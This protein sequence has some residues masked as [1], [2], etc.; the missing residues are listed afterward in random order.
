MYEVWTDGSC[1]PKKLS[2]KRRSSKG[3]STIGAIIKKDGKIVHYHSAHIGDDYDNNQAEYIAFIYAIKKVIEY[4]IEEVV[5]YTDSNVVTHQM[6]GR[7]VARSESIIPY[8]HEAKELLS[9]LDKWKII[10]I[11]R[12]QNT[13]ADRLASHPGIILAT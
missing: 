5:F 13:E 11:P 7:T 3:Y 12:K 10:W 2:K 1:K 9:C 8:Y 6:T 4:N